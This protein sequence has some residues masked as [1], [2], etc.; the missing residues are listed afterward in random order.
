MEAL[1]VLRPSCLCFSSWVWTPPSISTAAWRRRFTT[2]CVAGW[3]QCLVG[4]HSQAPFKKSIG[5]Q[6]CQFEL[7]NICTI[8]GFYFNEK[9]CVL[10]FTSP[11]YV[12]YY[13]RSG[14]P[15]NIIA[16]EACWF[17]TH[18]FV[19][20]LWPFSSAKVTTLLTLL[21][22]FILIF[23]PVPSPAVPAYAAYFRFSLEVRYVA[24]Q[25][26]PSHSLG[27]IYCCVE[28]ISF[29]SCLIPFGG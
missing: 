26:L 27:S 25:S 5:F 24:F 29:H 19:Q 11:A 28:F 7:I 3:L 4:A 6:E 1:W 14:T 21:L 18:A 23:C 15:A 8:I 17:F 16:C 20:Y 22:F 12:N 10:A 13:V 2:G 9:H